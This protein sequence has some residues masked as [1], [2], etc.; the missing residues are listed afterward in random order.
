[1]SASNNIFSK[2]SSINSSASFGS[3]LQQ[4]RIQRSLAYEESFQKY[5]H[6]FEE[7]MMMD[8]IEKELNT[9]ADKPSCPNPR[10]AL[11]C[12][13]DNF[14]DTEWGK[15][16]T[17]PDVCNVRTSIAKRFRRR[18]RLPFPL[19]EH[20]VHIC[21]TYNIFEMIYSS[22]IP[23]EAKVLASLRI[24][25]RDHSCDDINVESNSMIGES[26]ANYLFKQFVEGMANL[27]YP[28]FVKL[29]TGELLEKVMS[30][31]SRLGLLRSLQ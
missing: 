16:I 25:A 24:L 22:R 1:M 12:R 11:F 31:Y 28:N 5:E 29:P 27:V 2:L 14:W 26:T 9:E 8:I 15:M 18:F 13:A 19:F 3:Y 7:Q 30:T 21:K 20:L 10:R 17:H 4:Q 23:T 6:D